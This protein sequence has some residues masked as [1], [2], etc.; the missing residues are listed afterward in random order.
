VYPFGDRDLNRRIF[1]AM[2]LDRLRQYL[3]GRLALNESG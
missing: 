3:Q 2:A 1:A